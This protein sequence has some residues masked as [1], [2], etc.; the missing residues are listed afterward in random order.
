MNKN[1]IYELKGSRFGSVVKND[2]SKVLEY[3]IKRYHWLNKDLFFSINNSL[4]EQFKKIVMSLIP[5]IEKDF[6]A[7]LR[8]YRYIDS[9]NKFEFTIDKIDGDYTSCGYSNQSIITDHFF[10]VITLNI[11]NLKNIG[12]SERHNKSE[13]GYVLGTYFI[14]NKELYDLILKNPANFVDDFKPNGVMF[15]TLPED[16][17][18]IINYTLKKN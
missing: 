16:A 3:Y 4:F 8:T 11:Y 7:G 1:I 2:L 13:P 12:F 15:N 9:G 10:K 14:S 18:E 5:K 17:K 6:N